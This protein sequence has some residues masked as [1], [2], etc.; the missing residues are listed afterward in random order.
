MGKSKHSD[1]PRERTWVRARRDQTSL[2]QWLS[3]PFIPHEPVYNPT[4]K[5]GLLRRGLIWMTARY[6]KACFLLMLAA[7]VSAWG[8]FFVFSLR[9][10]SHTL[11]SLSAIQLPLLV[12]LLWTLWPTLLYRLVGLPKPAARPSGRSARQRAARAYYRGSCVTRLLF[13]GNAALLWVWLIAFAF[14]RYDREAGPWL[15]IAICLVLLP[16]LAACIAIPL[17]AIKD[18]VFTRPSLPLPRQNDDVLLP[19]QERERS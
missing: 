9:Q 16:I 4:I 15:N 5:A 19:N 2:P 17:K 10:S 12:G 1:T 13:A 6:P 11:L 7:I 3:Q 18:S 8:A 14:I